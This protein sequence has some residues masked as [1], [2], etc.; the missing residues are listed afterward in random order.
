MGTN[1]LST[2]MGRRIESLSR[3]EM[4]DVINHCANEI[5]TLTETVIDG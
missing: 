1:Q 5:K 4:I 3:E 2:W